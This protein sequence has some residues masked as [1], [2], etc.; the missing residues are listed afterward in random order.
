ML[1]LVRRAMNNWGLLLASVMGLLA[2]GAMAV[3]DNRTGTLR[4]DSTPST[5]AWY[6]LAFAGFVLALWWAE[7]RDINR[8]W[9][10]TVPVVFR[11]LMLTTSPTLSD[12]VYRYIWDGHVV[13][14]GVNPYT[15]S[16]SAAELDRYEIPARRLANNP[17]LA[18]P[19][20]PAAHGIFSAASVALPPKP[21]NLQVLMTLFD[22][23]TALVIAKLLVLAGLPDRRIMLYL[24]NPLVIVELAHGAHIDAA[25]VFFSLLALLLT[26]RVPSQTQ[27]RTGTPSSRQPLGSATMSVRRTTMLFGP[28]VALAVATL[29][30]PIPILL[31]PAVWGR[32]TR[33]QRSVY[34]A[35][36]VVPIAAF[37]SGFKVGR[38]GVDGSGYGLGSDSTGTG[39]FGSVRVYSQHF[40]F[41]ASFARWLEPLP[42]FG[43]IRVDQLIIA[44]LMVVV[45]VGTWQLATATADTAR[46]LR[47]SVVPLMG[48]L[49]LTPVV[50]P[51]YLTVVIALL[52]FLPPAPKE[53][54]DRW[55]LVA[56]WLYLAATASLSYL[57]YEDPSAFAERAWVR[58]VEW[59]PTLVLLTSSTF[60]VFFAT[61]AEKAES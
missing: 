31:L 35:T 33:I 13:T 42:S 59:L 48:Y 19:Y 37:G 27:R 45:V 30:R 26:L 57:T 38:F 4:A 12:D 54:T 14:E 28:P 34:G 41:N 5:I 25:M 43:S 51:W 21:I 10:W 58:N 53:S 22:L 61:Q 16:I 44:S 50:H 15:Y 60:W 49:L 52:P 29:I 9:L 6:F 3:L 1:W 55:L 46:L 7:R 17:T 8:I 39:V 18:S 40:R 36:M 20:L 56:P 24:W 23:A 32:W 11:V 47:L 2:F